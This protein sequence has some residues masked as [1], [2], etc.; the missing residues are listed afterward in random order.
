[1]APQPD[2]ASLTAAELLDLFSTLEAPTLA[3][4]N[5]EFSGR[6]LKQ[7]SLTARLLALCFR[8][9]LWPGTWLGK[10]FRSGPT[11]TGRGY[12]IFRHFGK[13]AQRFAMGTHIAPS[14]YDG[15]TAFQLVYRAYRSICGAL[16]IVDDVRRLEPG[17]Y[18]GVGTLGVAK[19]PRRSPILFM[20]TGPVAAYRGDVGVER[21]HFSLGEANG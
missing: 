12:N 18:L 2:L 14:R 19:H 5:G 8:M 21:D 15:K 4:M 10:G 11:A 13:V 17:V 6:L 7:N 3:E 1:M 16:D 20:M 9:P